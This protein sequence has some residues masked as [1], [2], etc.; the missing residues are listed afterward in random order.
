MKATKEQKEQMKKYYQE[1]REKMLSKACD[2]SKKLY[3]D[4]K[5]SIY[6]KNERRRLKRLF[7]ITIEDYN[8]MFCDQYGRCAIC[9]RHQNELKGKFQIDHN[10]ITGEVRG[11]LCFSCNSA[12]GKLNTPELCRRA[13]E[14][15]KGGYEYE[16]L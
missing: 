9:G 12:I 13:A 1:H 11:L 16:G 8:R 7:G 15:L 10:H 5:K 3:P 6:E 2:R 14:Y 4:N